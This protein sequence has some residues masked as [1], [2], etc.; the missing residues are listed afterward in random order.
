M[1]FNIW[2]WGGWNSGRMFNTGVVMDAVML[3]NASSQNVMLTAEYQ[4]SLNT[5]WEWVA[6]NLVLLL[7]E[8]CRWDVLSSQVRAAV[9]FTMCFTSISGSRC[10]LLCFPT[11][12]P[13]SPRPPTHVPQPTQ[14]SWIAATSLML[15]PQAWRFNATEIGNAQQC[16]TKYNA[17]G[18]SYPRSSK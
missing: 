15:S 3:H 18:N 6:Q 1:S 17:P 5:G 9:S 13:R 10:R 12:P 16:T 4:E 2:A 11:G 7:L 14:P 8:N